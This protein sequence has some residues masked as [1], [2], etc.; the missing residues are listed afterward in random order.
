MEG[1]PSEDKIWATVRDG[2]GAR[3]IREAQGN[4]PPER[5]EEGYPKEGRSKTTG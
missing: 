1:K 5:S 4:C 2:R 3:P